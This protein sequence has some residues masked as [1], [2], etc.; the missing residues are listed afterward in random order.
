M[1]P[2]DHT[3]KTL[4]ID[5]LTGGVRGVGNETSSFLLRKIIFLNSFSLVA[6][7]CL[8]SFGT[9]HLSAGAHKLGFFELFCSLIALGNILF[10]RHSKNLDPSCTFLLGLILVLL[11]FLLVSGGLQ[12]TGIYWFYGYPVVTF[13]LTGKRRGV[14]WLS[15]AFV[16]ALAI[17]LA[18]T[19]GYIAPLPYS[20][21]EIRQML[22][23]LFVVSLLVFFYEAARESNDAQILEQNAAVL[24]KNAALL[25]KVAEQKLMDK[26]LRESEE[27]FHKVIEHHVDA[28]LVV[29]QRNVVRF[30][31]PAARDLFALDDETLLGKKFGIPVVE[32]ET[33]EF[34]IPKRDGSVAIVEVRT[35]QIE[36]ENEIAYLESLRDITEQKQAQEAL[37]RSEEQLTSSYQREQKRRRLSDTLREIARVVSSTLDQQSVINIILAQLEAVIKFDRVTVMLLE[38]P[39][40]LRVV[41]K[42]DKSGC[43]DSETSFQIE[44]YPLNSTILQSKLPLLAPNVSQDA[45][46]VPTAATHDIQSFIGAP[47]LV[48]ETPIGILTVGRRDTTHYTEDDSQTVFAFATQVAT[49]IY[50][51]RLLENERKRLEQELETARQIQMSL[52]PA[53][54]P[55]IAG[56]EICGVSFPAR[57]V[58]GDFY[59]YF[60]FEQQHIGVAVGDVSGKG[61][62]AALMMALSFGLLST[63]ARREVSPATL[64]ERLNDEL[65]PHTERNRKNT[66]LCYLHLSLNSKEDTQAK[67]SWGFQVANAG[68]IAPLIRHRDGSIE[69][70]EATGLPLGMLRGTHYAELSGQLAPSEFLLLC[71]DGLVEAK[72]EAGELYGFERL[73]KCLQTTTAQTAQ[74]LQ[75]HILTDMRDFV[76]D[77][78]MHDDMTL[79]IVLHP[80]MTSKKN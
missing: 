18:G 25:E 68:L 43:E 38:E 64:L 33:T 76:T 80:A 71:S 69:W 23:S 2:V 56:L 65:R 41:A 7:L 73:S 37:Q 36:W 40:R 11:G 30:V 54:E 42:R 53:R 79:V 26:A 62:Q 39:G 22:A 47:L 59:N 10:F 15:A 57:E 70:L 8:T 77:T 28:I 9:L 35:V 48:R 31:N 14:L 21:A 72:N 63:E 16:L 44:K 51:A 3:L 45:R 55:R 12:K 75:E 24:K 46:W 5:I 58:G 74:A 52:F 19:F 34:E 61:L 1:K 78:E 27:R 67:A 50:N 66:A 4:W 6:L 32:G 20:S 49:A 60:V 29:D 17:A 13:F